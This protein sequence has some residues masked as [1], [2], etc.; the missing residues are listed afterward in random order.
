[1]CH[2]RNRFLN[3]H[4]HC[5]G[6][7]CI[8]MHDF[9]DSLHTCISVFFVHASEVYKLQKPPEFMGKG[10]YYSTKTL[11]NIKYVV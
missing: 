10:L 5:F 7:S 8:L 9:A 3:L 1:M 6:F 11:I 4:F 2:V